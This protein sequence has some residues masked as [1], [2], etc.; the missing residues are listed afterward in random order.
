[1]KAFILLFFI[2]ILSI[3]CYD[4]GAVVAYAQAHWNRVNH[5]CGNYLS[6]SPY[7]YFGN[8]ACGYASQGG[9]CANFVSQS[10]IA[11]GHPFL[12]GHKEWCR[13]YPCGKEEVGATRLGN[14]LSQVFGWKRTCGFQQPPPS[15]IR[16]GDVLIYHAD[17]CS[18][19]S[20]HA[21]V[22]VS[23]NGNDVRIS[24]HSNNQHNI[25]YTYMAKTKGYYEWLLNPN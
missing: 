23:A 7:S 16:P 8:E 4:R 15:N 25:H 19:Y 20:A 11:G 18:S 10:L 13:G 22:V 3:H 24:C 6:C 2:T 1:M 9:D 14:C 12:K 21:T 17:S 5:Q